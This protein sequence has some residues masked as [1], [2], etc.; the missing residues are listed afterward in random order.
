MRQ[1]E[2]AQEMPGSGPGPYLA[3]LHQLLL[4]S[5]VLIGGGGVLR[6]GDGLRGRGSG[7][8][9]CMLAQGGTG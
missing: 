8:L 4:R 3:A 9:G 1:G 6:S 2:G 7:L 5:G